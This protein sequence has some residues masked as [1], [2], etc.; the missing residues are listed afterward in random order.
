M[1]KSIT[2]S[3]HPL[4]ACVA[5]GRIWC[6]NRNG[7]LAIFSYSG[8]RLFVLQVK[9]ERRGKEERRKERRKKK[10]KRGLKNNLI[11]FSFFFDL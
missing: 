6:G 10:E 9:K 3:A 8:D 2:G 11:N 4:C 1:L 5:S 7:Q